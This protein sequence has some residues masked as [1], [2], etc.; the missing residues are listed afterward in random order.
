M[1]FT[2]FHETTE[3]PY[4]KKTNH[5]VLKEVYMNYYVLFRKDVFDKKGKKVF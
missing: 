4:V 3:K 5:F 1:I 2:Y